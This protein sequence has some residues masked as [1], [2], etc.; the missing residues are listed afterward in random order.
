MAQKKRT[1]STDTSGGQYEKLRTL[2]RDRDVYMH[3]KEGYAYEILSATLHGD[4]SWD[5]ASVCI[6]VFYII[7][8]S[9]FQYY[10]LVFIF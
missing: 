10:R 2:I 1:A 4:N 9:F 5:L 6:V 8:T 3:W 7:D